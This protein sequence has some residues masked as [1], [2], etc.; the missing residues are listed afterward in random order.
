MV[1]SQISKNISYKED[2]TIDTEDVGHKAIPYEMELFKK[3]VIVVF[4][5]PK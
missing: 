1:F 4:G 2:A 3:D 5:K